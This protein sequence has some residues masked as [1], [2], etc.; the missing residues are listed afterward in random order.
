MGE[1][2]AEVLR[3]RYFSREAQ[4]LWFFGVLWLCNLY[5]G[6]I[7]VF[8][9]RNWWIEMCLKMLVNLSGVLERLWLHRTALTCLLWSGNHSSVQL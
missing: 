5:L 6:L 3:L 2:T 8:Q 1:W 4:L 9:V 7:L